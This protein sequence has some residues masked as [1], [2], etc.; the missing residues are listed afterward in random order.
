MAKIALTPEFISS[1][2]GVILSLMFSYIPKF[3]EWYSK[4]GSTKKRLIML[5]LLLLV[6]ASVFGA[7]CW[8]VAGDLGLNISCNK[9]GL[10]GM[11][12]VF[13]SAII[14]NQAIYAISPQM[15][16]TKN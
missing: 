14:S 16:D 3:R 1:I 6:S 11:I 4:L 8:D 5:G 12:S 10:I 13:V 9:H 2:A 15:A 7:A